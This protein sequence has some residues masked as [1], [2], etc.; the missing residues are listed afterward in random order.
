MRPSRAEVRACFRMWHS[1]SKSNPDA[2]SRIAIGTGKGFLSR[3][4]KRSLMRSLRVC[5]YQ[6]SV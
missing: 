2:S 4:A 3:I 6:M 1:P 5:N